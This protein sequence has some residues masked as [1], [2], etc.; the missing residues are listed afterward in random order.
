MDLKDDNFWN[1]IMRQENYV[2]K[3]YKKFVD[4]DTISKEI[5][6]HLK[7]VGTIPEELMPFVKQIKNALINVL[8]SDQFHLLYRQL[9]K[10]YQIS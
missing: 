1:L 9:H 7:P 8:L 5:R 10:N 4:Y 3:I 2:D 6:R